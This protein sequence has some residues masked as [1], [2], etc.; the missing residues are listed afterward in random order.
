MRVRVGTFQSPTHP[1][2]THLPEE[3]ICG[4]GISRAWVA[5]PAKV[6]HHGDHRGMEYDLQQTGS[7]GD[8]GE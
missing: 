8:D 3:V 6:G 7:G 5:V 4:V 1:A 2:P